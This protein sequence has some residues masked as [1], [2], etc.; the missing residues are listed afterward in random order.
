MFAEPVDASLDRWAS[1]VLRE[2]PLSLCLEQEGRQAIF[3]LFERPSRFLF[4]RKEVSD[5]MRRG[6]LSK[7]QKTTA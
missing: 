1:M 4:A 5:T 3:W 2:E 6:T 7:N